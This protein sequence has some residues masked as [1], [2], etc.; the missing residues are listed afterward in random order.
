MFSLS[1]TA[2]SQIPKLPNPTPIQTPKIRSAPSE[3]KPAHLYYLAQNFAHPRLPFTIQKICVSPKVVQ[4]PVQTHRVGPG[5][6]SLCNPNP[7]K[8]TWQ[9]LQNLRLPKLVVA[10]Q[11]GPGNLVPLQLESNKTNLAASEAASAVVQATRTSA[12]LRGPELPHANST[13]HSKISK[14]PPSPEPNPRLHP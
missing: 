9:H 6:P 4:A 11:V 1:A 7:T 14:I 8:M 12:R 2:S 10:H 13:N 3:S 5:N